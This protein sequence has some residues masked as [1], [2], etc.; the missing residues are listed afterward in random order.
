MTLQVPPPTAALDKVGPVRAVESVAVIRLRRLSLVAGVGAAVVWALTRALPADGEVVNHGGIRLLGTIA[1]H[2][3]HP[4]HGPEFLGVVASAAVT[5]VALALLGTMAALGLGLVGGIVLADVTWGERLPWSVRTGRWLL[6]AAFV[7]VRS[8]H[9]L[10]WALLFVSVLGFD[11]LVAVLALALPFAAQAAQVFGETF[12]AVPPEPLRALRR[13]GVRAPVAFA[14]ALLPAT[15]SLMLS[16]GFYRF[17]CALRSAVVLGVAGVGG[18]GFEMTVSLQSRNW[19]EVWTLVAAVLLLSAAVELWSVRVRADLAVVT[20]SDWSTGRERP[21][22]D[23]RPAGLRRSTTVSLLLLVPATG[24]A[25]WWVGLAPSALVDER[26]RAATSRL[27]ADLWPPAPPDGDWLAL[28]TATLDTLAMAVLAMVV[29][30]AVTLLLGP[31]ASR[32]RADRRTATGWSRRCLWAA[33]RLALLVLRSVPPTVWAVV[34][35]FA[36]FPG[37]LPGAL[38][39]GVYTGGVLGRL[40]AEAWE[41]LDLAPRDA[42]RQAGVPRMA[43][44]TVAL[45]PASVHHLLAYSTNRFEIC[46]RDTAI[47]GVV[48]AAG[49][50]R[51]LAEGF[52]SVDYPVVAAVL[53]ASLVV[54]LSVEMLGRAV[55]RSLRA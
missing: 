55:R 53:I 41:T 36:L 15:A 54:S 13:A 10:V 49:L 24:L 32:P 16:Y 19:D 27:V 20:C 22:R 18:L 11:P 51:L 45:G 40:A 46:V 33:T 7:A 23:G 29:A 52:A 42:L 28:A 30:V 17:E 21:G 25:W 2:A 9:E 44:A 1:A 6:R 43:A 14:H 50:G 39:L 4:A 47:V 31:W 48:G 35:L 8:V 5:T 37:I 38:A 12:D 34:A 26:T 3:L